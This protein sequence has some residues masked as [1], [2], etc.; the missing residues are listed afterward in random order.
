M[1]A[2][3]DTPSHSSIEQARVRRAPRISVFL[4]LGAALGIVAALIL[5]FSFDGIAEES[6]YT[7]AQ[8]TTG[9]VFGFLLLACVPIG[10]AL[11]GTVAV[12][13]DRTVGRR[14]RRVTISHERIRTP[15][16]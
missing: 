12:V 13:L 6:P 7:T 4:L 2:M 14:T 9:Q 8:Y 1:D 16:D 10:I 15:E 11:G 3:S 5:T